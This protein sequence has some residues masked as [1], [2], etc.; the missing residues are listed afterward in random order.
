MTRTKR[1]ANTHMPRVSNVEQEVDALTD[2]IESLGSPEV[3]TDFLGKDDTAQMELMEQYGK[4]Y[5]F[6]Q[7][8]MM[9]FA[10]MPMM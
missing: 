9:I 6:Y 8:Q 1:I 7:K 2:T 5:R 4:L 10:L 3:T